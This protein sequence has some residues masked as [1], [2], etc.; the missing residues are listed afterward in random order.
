VL[1]KKLINGEPHYLIKWKDYPECEN[2]WEPLSGLEHLPII[3]EF[4]AQQEADLQFVTPLPQICPLLK[5]ASCGCVLDYLG[6]THVCGLSLCGECKEEEFQ[7]KCPPEEEA[8]WQPLVQAVKDQVDAL[9]VYCPN[10]RHGCSRVKKMGE[11][12]SHLDLDCRFTSTCDLCG[13]FVNQSQLPRHKRDVCSQRGVQCPWCQKEGIAKQ[14]DEHERDLQLCVKGFANLANHPLV[15]TSNNSK[16][17]RKPEN[18]KDFIVDDEYEE[19][20]SKRRVEKQYQK[21]RAKR[22]RRG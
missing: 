20:E 15:K 3:A 2:S 4:E 6:S 12:Q 7:C 8:R 21:W 14:I 5:C 22:G 10:K 1:R 17:K 13:E 19:P 11:L 18:S 16:L 9:L